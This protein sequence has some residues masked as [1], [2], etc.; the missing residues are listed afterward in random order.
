MIIYI[1]KQNYSWPLNILLDICV[2]SKICEAF[3]GWKT[4]WRKGLIIQTVFKAQ[5]NPRFSAKKGFYKI[6]IIT[7]DTLVKIIRELVAFR[8][9]FRYQRHQQILREN[10][11]LENAMAQRINHTD[12]I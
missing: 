5:E 4:Q 1:P 7:I 3:L 8:N 2:I 10:F 9:S 6:S 12:R 11:R